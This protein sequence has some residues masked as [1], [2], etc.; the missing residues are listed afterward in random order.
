MQEIN[1]PKQEGNQEIS[2][3]MGATATIPVGTWKKVMPPRL[4]RQPCAKLCQRNAEQASS[5][6]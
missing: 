5:G 4:A 1:L 6:N 3:G 2:S